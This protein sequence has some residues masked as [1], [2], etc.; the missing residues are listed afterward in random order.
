MNS[1]NHRL[2]A[3]GSILVYV[4]VAQL[5]AQVD[6]TTYH[7][8]NF[9]TGLNSQE[10]TLTPEN[11]N[12][13]QF[14]K[15]FTVPVDGSVY[16]Q[17]LYLSNVTVAGAT[18]RVVYVATEH[19]SVYALDADTGGVYW[20]K[21]LIPN[22]GSAVNSGTDLKCGDI[23][24]QVGITGTPV[25]DSTTGTLYVVAKVKVNGVISQ[26]L[27]A[28]DVSTGEEKFGGPVSI[29]ASVPGTASDGD[30][31]LV[32]FNPK[33][34]NQ[35]AALLLENGH[36][37]IA[38]SS[39]CDNNPWHGWV[40]SYGASSLVQ[41]GAYNPSANGSSS[42]V[43]MGAGGAAADASGNIY[44][45]TGNGSWN[46]TTNLG[47]SIIKL[48]PPANGSFPVIDYFTP[49]NQA[50]LS[51]RDRDVS[52]GGLVLLPD[53]SSGQQLL[54]MIG[55]EG[56]IYLVDRNN[57][58]RFCGTLPGC[59]S[60]DPNIVQEIPNVFS[61]FWGT[62]AY[63]NGN[64]YW[65]GGDGDTGAAEPLKA[66][67]FDAGG[68]G[69]ISTTPT[70]VTA[71]AFH[72]TGPMPSVS[73][74]GQT[75]G[76]VWGLDNGAYQ[77]TCSNGVNCQV[78]YAYDATDL[79]HVLYNSSQA[80]GNRDVPGSAIKFTTPTV[81]NGKVYVGSKGAIS[82]FGLLPPPLPPAAIP[83]FSPAAGTYTTN[84]SVT[85]AD[86]TP[87]AVIYYT[88]DGTIP[89]TSSA[90]FTSALQVNTSTVIKAI[91]IAAGSSNSAVA[92][93]TYTIAAS[94]TA[95]VAVNLDASFNVN[96]IDNDGTPVTNGGIDALG[97]AYSA[98]LLNSP[99]VWSGSV[100][101][102]GGAGLPSAVSGG[103]LAL[104]QGNYSTLQLL[105]TGIR[106]NQ[107]NQTF[108]VTYTDGTTTTVTQ[109][110]SDWFTPQGYAGESKA[111]TMA[112]RLTASGSPGT[113]GPYY[114][115]GYAFALN[116]AKTVKSVTLPS[117]RHVVVLAVTL[118]PGTGSPPPPP[119]PP[120]EPAPVSLSGVANVHAIFS[121]G[122][123]VT[124]GGLDTFSNAYSGNQLGASI[125]WSGTTF[126]L[127]PL[128]LADAVSNI[129]VPLPAGNFATL[130]FLATAVRGNHPNQAFTVTYTDG[131]TTALNQSLSDWHTPQAYAGESTA[132]TT[133]YRV[134]AKGTAGA[135]PFYVYGYAL[136]LDPA[137]T[138]K[139]V[140]LPANRD[141]V[142]LAATLI[143][144]GT[145]PPPPPPPPPG[146]PTAVSLS[147]VAN[148][149]G[150]F[151][152]GSAVI[153]GGMDTFDNA[154]SSVQL[155]AS[156]TWS[157]TTFTLGAAGVADAVSNATIP[158]PAGNFSTLQL[159]ATGIRGN[160]PNQSFTVTY[161]DGTSTAVSQSLSDWHTS[162]GYS[163]ESQAMT[164]AYRLT[165]NGSS[166]TGP[167]YLYGY[168][169]SIDSQK[170]VK[171]V[172]L[173][174]NRDVVVIAASL[175]P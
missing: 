115:Y 131:T 21:S 144:A 22:G 46:G 98:A 123:A 9:R 139:S 142:I 55:K 88:T 34:E 162:Q 68:T 145:T 50:S 81:V 108:T 171:S 109:S 113:T 143:P 169:F 130:Q 154:Y 111:V 45:A 147:A 70:S 128:G 114:L 135:G 42:G 165:A 58:G 127:G 17:P 103:T 38:W 119:P 43:W 23:A 158:L 159:L 120:G 64:I 49:Y 84:Q 174:A 107:L 7:N 78:L 141:V 121:D 19:D 152:D 97:N 77:S 35:R 161:T 93:S 30:G 24:T 32:T 52:S 153:G 31:S 2:A 124:N 28:L 47:D 29:Q 133:A 71:K 61:G 160:H 10:T 125:K 136:T 33:M 112:Y 117:N 85:I 166:G 170:T 48:G 16:A 26:H 5:H 83:T 20:K 106:G 156:I 54:T 73:S 175:V 80:P 104:P 65:A 100:F 40:L 3:V 157:G 87:G 148:V 36:V 110:L 72:F 89:T 25:I 96:A 101:T 18:H 86:T 63:W 67:S 99:L 15:L 168:A 164:T 118:I 105:A 76:I 126:S 95:P 57:M 90:I 163:G 102:L 134:T 1:R 92:S 116:S 14:G 79:S 91:A 129:T 138:V 74:N 75:N 69:L 151:A 149:H 122:T 11:L 51:G 172:T 8:D 27:H 137:K 13:T 44:F 94:G 41:E 60:S 6:V 150:I 167:F 53:L 146:S 39:H 12:S 56:K 59:T 62:P 140:T 66:Y 173:P 37:I 4:G 155:G 82:A 132:A